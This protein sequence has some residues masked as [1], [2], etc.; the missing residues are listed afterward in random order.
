MEP[1]SQADRHF[2]TECEVEVQRIV[3]SEKPALANL[4]PVKSIA[5]LVKKVLEDTAFK[6]ELNQY[7]PEIKSSLVAGKIAH[8]LTDPTLERIKSK[9]MAL[10]ENEKLKYRLERDP[11]L[12]K[13]FHKN[14]TGTCRSIEFRTVDPVRYA[15]AKELIPLMPEQLRNH[16]IPG[17]QSS[18]TLL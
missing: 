7:S 10:P 8:L 4:S 15:I 1:L 18:C 14:L 6:A 9:I 11:G 17:M 13:D 2:Y 5:Q 16:G 3:L 12:N